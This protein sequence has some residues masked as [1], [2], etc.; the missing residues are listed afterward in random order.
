[1]EVGRDNSSGQPL[2]GWQRVAA[3]RRGRAAGL[4]YAN[5][6]YTAVDGNCVVLR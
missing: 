5:D 3:K 2:R 6:L 4:A 1:M